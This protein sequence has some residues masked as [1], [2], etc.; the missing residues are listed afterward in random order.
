VNGTQSTLLATLGASATSYQVTGLTPASTVPF[1]LEAFNGTVVADS[2]QVSVTLPLAT[3]ILTATIASTTTS[4]ARLLQ[5]NT[6]GSGLSSAAR[7]LR[8]TGSVASGSLLAAFIAFEPGSGGTP[9]LAVS[10]NID[11]AWQ[12]AGG[13][14]RNGV[15]TGAWFYIINSAGGSNLT[16]T[17]TP[18]AAVYMSIGLHE[19]RVPAGVTLDGTASN[20]G[21]SASIATGVC[22]VSATGELVLSGFAQGVS[23]LTTVTA[24]GP[25][26]LENN[27]PIGTIY[28]GSATADDTNAGSAEGALFTVNTAVRFAAMTIS[29]KTPAASSST[30]VNLAWNTVP[31]ALGYR[32]YQVNGTQSTLLATLGASAMTYQVTGLTPAST[33]TFYVEAFNGSVIA[34]SAA[35]VVTL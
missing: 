27:Q 11:G 28:E 22:P 15:T 17:V 16:V 35:A 23:A 31:Q 8:Y 32:V 5:K 24:G 20:T 10:D 2:A 12:Q 4:P 9:T 30:A 18:S 7:Q 3:P 34:D 1:Y 33:V 25:F 6:Q 19:Y 26:T 21:T 29:F 14:V 13:Y